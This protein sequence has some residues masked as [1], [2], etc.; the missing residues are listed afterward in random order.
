MK[1]KMREAIVTNKNWFNNKQTDLLSFMRR[2]NLD[3]YYG[4]KQAAEEI[5]NEIFIQKIYGFETLKEKPIIID[6]GSNIGIAMLFF[7]KQYPEAKVL[8]FEPDPNAYAILEKNI[9]A[10]H[11]KEVVAVNSALSKNNGVTPFFGEISGLDADSRGNSIIDVW[12]QQRK[13]SS[14]ILVNTER[15]STYIKSEVDFLKI[16]IEGAELQVLQELGEKIRFVRE[17]VIE[18]HE[19]KHVSF[20]NNLEDI[21]LI[22][23]NHKFMVATEEI[24]INESLP[25][26]IQ[27]WIRKVEPIF[28]M[29]R[30][31]RV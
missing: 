31:K 30:A 27:P 15:L 22:L 10:N 12:G 7:K 18:V 26:E 17:L 16:D 11:L 4:N 1:K 14:K 3:I 20:N 23:K 2:K 6:A 9:N 29:L 8:C 19:T 21:K 5:Y 24:F 28:T 25:K 13:T